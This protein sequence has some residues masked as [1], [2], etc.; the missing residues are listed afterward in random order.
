MAAQVLGEN[1]VDY[2]AAEGFSSG[3][4]NQNKSYGKTIAISMGVG[5]LIGLLAVGVMASMMKSVR[6]Q[7]GASDYVRHGSMHLTNQRDIFLYSHVTR[8]PRPKSNSTGS[9]G[10]R[11]GA[12]G[13][14]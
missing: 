11:G 1:A 7:N 4:R 12:G 3:I 2:A 9:S 8:T 13:R 6:S 14:M 10:N 5:L